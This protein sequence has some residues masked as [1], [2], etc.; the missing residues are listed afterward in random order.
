MGT[1]ESHREDGDTLMS[2]QQAVGLT[3]TLRDVSGGFLSTVANH[4]LSASIPVAEIRVH[5]EGEH[6][7]S[8]HN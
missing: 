1:R 6:K 4:V 5:R 7:H 3:D 2:S 8:R